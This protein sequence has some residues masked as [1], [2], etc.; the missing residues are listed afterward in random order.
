MT[1]NSVKLIDSTNNN[2]PNPENLHITTNISPQK[3]CLCSQ[4]CEHNCT[5]GWYDRTF[6]VI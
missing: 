4:I 5:N 2:C 6:E 3:K 1:A